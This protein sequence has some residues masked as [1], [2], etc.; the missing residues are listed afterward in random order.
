MTADQLWQLVGA[1]ALVSVPLA[2]A[3]YVLLRRLSAWLARRLPSRSLRAY[4]A[5]RRVPL[6]AE[7]RR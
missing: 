4:P 3:L 7:H 6:A 5:R 2:L 1:S